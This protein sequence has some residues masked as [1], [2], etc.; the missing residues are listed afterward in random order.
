MSGSGTWRYVA[1]MSE[2][3]DRSETPSR[4][5][6]PVH[7]LTYG[8]YLGVLCVWCCR[9]LRDERRLAGTSRGIDGEDVPDVEVYA[10][11]NCSSRAR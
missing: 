5:V 11:L 2:G 9:P 8:Q 6:P 3:P 10:C 7:D 4:D 1:A